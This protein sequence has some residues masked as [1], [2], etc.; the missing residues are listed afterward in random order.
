[1]LTLA[2]VAAAVALLLIGFALGAIAMSVL[3]TG[4]MLSAEHAAEAAIEYDRRSSGNLDYL[5]AEV[6][7]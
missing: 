1:M 6:R 7:A 4:H 3:I 5:S 2:V